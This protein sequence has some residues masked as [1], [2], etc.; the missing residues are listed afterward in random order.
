MTRFH[1]GGAWSPW[2]RKCGELRLD[3]M[4]GAR[5]FDGR[6]LV[7]AEGD[8]APVKGWSVTWA[9][10][11]GSCREIV[12][13]GDFDWLLRS[14]GLQEHTSLMYRNLPAY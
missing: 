3:Q 5:S 13:C 1:W 6:S 14:H 4:G 7:T 2:L 12:P 10:H 9:C 8:I 11:Q